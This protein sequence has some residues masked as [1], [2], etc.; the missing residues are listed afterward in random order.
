MLIIFLANIFY[1]H[2][3][4]KVDTTDNMQVDTTGKTINKF[5]DFRR[6]TKQI[7]GPD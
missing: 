5:D 4:Y 3:Q 2:S 6:K 1:S 7:Q